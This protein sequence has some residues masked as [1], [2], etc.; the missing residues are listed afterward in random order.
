MEVIDVDL[1][2]D[3]FLDHR[4]RQLG[5]EGLVVAKHENWPCDDLCQMLSPVAEDHRLAR[6][7]DAMN[8]PVAFAETACQL[9]LLEI[10]DAKDVRHIQRLSGILR[11]ERAL[12]RHADLREQVPADPLDLRQ[13]KLEGEL[14]RE[15]LPQALLEVFCVDRL[16][17]LVL[18]DHQV[19]RQDATEVGLVELGTRDVGQDDAAAVGKEGF[20]FQ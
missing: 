9:L 17:H 19:R 8:D 5:R 14:D 4:R 1:L 10:H 3:A 12:L 15:H 20:A 11:K 7:G 13:G 2:F 16:V 18:A 6:A